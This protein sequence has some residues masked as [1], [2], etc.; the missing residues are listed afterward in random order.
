MEKISKITGAAAPLMLA[1]VDT[2]LIIRIERLTSVPKDQLGPYAFEALRYRDDGSDAP[3]FVLNQ[4]VFRNAPILLAGANFGC[5]SSREGAVSALWGSG[6]RC[7]IAESF[8]DIFRNN[9]FQNGLLPVQLEASELAVL[10]RDA[11]GG[12]S[13]TVDLDQQT[14]TAPRGQIFSFEIE[15]LRRNALLQGLDEIGQTMLR[16]SD[17]AAWQQRDSENRPWMWALPLALAK[18]ADIV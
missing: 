8:G 11:A 7:V 3:A 18:T 6:I 15:P 1:N 16:A 17:I 12:A 5:G 14:V 9:C 2:D 4:P 10:S 13:V